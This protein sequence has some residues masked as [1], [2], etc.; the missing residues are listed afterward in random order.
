MRT[1]HPVILIKHKFDD[2]DD[3][4]DDDDDDVDD[5]AKIVILLE[6]FFIWFEW[7][8]VFVISVSYSTF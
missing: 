8:C 6:I 3:D 1:C 2:A 5:D 7:L 4:D